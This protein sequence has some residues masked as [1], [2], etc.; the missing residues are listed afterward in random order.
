MSRMPEIREPMDQWAAKLLDAALQRH[1]LWCMRYGVGAEV[2]R[3]KVRFAVL[4]GFMAGSGLLGGVAGA[5]MAR[6][7]G[8]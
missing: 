4:V 1:T 2:Q 6:W 7:F 5:A 3:Q 8:G